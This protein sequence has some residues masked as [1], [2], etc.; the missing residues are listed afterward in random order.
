MLTYQDRL[1]ALRA[2]KME[3]TQDKWQVIGSMNH[4]DWAMILP[5]LECR[6]VVQAVSGSGENIN[7]VILKGVQVK[8]NHPNG[9]FY[10]A[11]ACGE[12]FKALLDAHPVYLD[13]LCSLAGAVMSNFMS[14][15]Q[16]GWKP[17]FSYDHLRAEQE[18]YRIGHGIG[19]TQH[20]CPDLQIGLRLGWQGILDNIH[21]HRSLHAPRADEFYAGL[22][23]VVAGIQGWIQ[24]HALAAREMAATEADLQRRENLLA[25]AEINARL[26]TQPPQTLR[27][28][29]QWIAWYLM[30]ARMYNG[31]GALGRLDVLLQPFYERDMA[32]GVLTDDETIFHIACLLL[33]DTTYAQ[34][35]GPDAGGQDV[36][37][38]I[39]YLVLEAIDRLRIPANIG[40]CVGPDVDTGLLERGVEIQFKHK[41]GFPKFL[42]IQNTVEGF[43]RNGYPVELGRERVYSGCHWS[44]L[45]GREY[46]L[47][48]I[49]KI[50]FVAVFDVAL[51][52]M[53]ADASS[54]PSL[55]KLWQAFESHLKR[56]VQVTAE[57]IAFHLEH[58]HEVFP[59]LALDLL[60]YGPIE[61]G[62]DAS[63]GGV[64]FYNICVDGSGLATVADSLAAIEQRIETEGRL[65][66]ADLAS[67]LEANWAGPEGERARLMMKNIP[68][69]GRGGSR[70]DAWAARLSQTF[71]RLIKAQPT[72]GFILVP[73]LFS[74]VSN[75]AMGKTLGAT[76]NGRR[77]GEP[78]SH[79]ANPDPGFRSDGAPTALA[80][81]VASVQPGYGNTAPLQIELDPRLARD[82]DQV[83]SLIKSHFDLGGTQ[84]NLNVLDKH[85]VL[86]AHRD[87]SKYPDFIVRLTGFSV[88]FASL[89]PEFRQMVVDRIL[90]E[91]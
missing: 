44:A 51:R 1:D 49:V 56:C 35:G 68:R 10:G 3:H 23:A 12:N 50:N 27:E 9:S 17:E 59:E 82:T 47:N 73:G 91:S 67:H 61:K 38:R 74:W 26:V 81:A 31:S 16:V 54:A 72:E 66:W 69:F 42:G 14:Y 85:K 15:R 11:R 22:E 8:S 32:A 62:L 60:C 24:R 30:A 75:I 79:G 65:T 63:H 52:E 28:A 70:A 7:D 83:A 78:I 6:Q 34:L 90:A 53:L 4:D 2:K 58:M 48:D 18:K 19:G 37:H 25:I 5:P 84:I 55:D 20:F 39:S 13:P 88:Y 29:C 71:T 89:S 21:R 36:T 86:E 40:V 64:E 46:T 76:P 77:A 80:V 43:A 41:M 87:P 33:R 57:G 45:P